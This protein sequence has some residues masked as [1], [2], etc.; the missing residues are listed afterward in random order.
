MSKHS[1]LADLHRLGRPVVLCP[2]EIRL[3]L[4]TGKP[5]KN[6]A[7]QWYVDSS[8]RTGIALH[9]AVGWNINLSTDNVAFFQEPNVL[10]LYS[11]LILRVGQPLSW[12]PLRLEQREIIG[13]KRQWND[14]L[15]KMR[16]EWME[17][18][19]TWRM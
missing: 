8:G 13:L 9:D 11:Q 17:F 1:K 12:Q 18:K 2:A 6:S 16:S 7:R 4:A 10:N 15:Q 14:E 3:D 5:L 19:K